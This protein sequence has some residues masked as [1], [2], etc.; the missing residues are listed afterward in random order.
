MF[1]RQVLV[2]TIL[3]LWN[4]IGVKEIYHVTITHIY[5]GNL[6]DRFDISKK[7][8]FFKELFSLTTF[9][10]MLKLNFFKKLFKTSAYNYFK[11]WS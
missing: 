6:R 5:D 8:F 1:R 10:D 7:C 3:K 2:E 11:T 9:T 4:N